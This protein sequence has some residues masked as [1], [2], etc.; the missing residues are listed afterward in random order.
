MSCIAIIPARSGS[1]GIPNKNLAMF[2]GR[3]LLEWTI[4]AALK[5]GR[6]DH[7]VI[8]TDSQVIA[9]AAKQ[10]GGDVPFLRPENLALDTSPTMPAVLH[11]LSH[12][13]AS[14]VVLLQPTSPLRTA[15]DIRAALD[16]HFA[17]GRPVVSVT[18]AKPW[19][20]TK[21]S[22]GALEAVTRL[23][24][25]RQNESVFAPN[26]AIYIA[27]A[28]RLREGQTWWDAP[29]AYEMPAERSI[30]IDAPIDMII[31]EAL[32]AGSPRSVSET[33]ALSIAVG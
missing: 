14:T 26:G 6:F 1:K 10:M 19:L 32:M 27:Q 16:L 12:Y 7:V 21:S 3:P 18:A 24:A 23:V 13:D 5:S 11:A 17:T 28:E 20:F 2:G 29:V 22:S 30:D 15:I 25:Q 33:E 4:E 31:G 8:S 9:N